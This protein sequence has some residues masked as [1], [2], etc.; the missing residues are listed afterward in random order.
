MN[1][2]VITPTV[3]PEG[4]ELVAKA[5][6]RQTW[7][8]FEWLICSPAEPEPV[9][10][11]GMAGRWIPDDFEGGF[12][13]LNRAYNKLFKEAQGELIVSLQ[14]WV[15]V[16]PEGLEKFWYQ[17]NATGG[18]IT[19]VG[20]QYDRLGPDGKPIN[21][22]W[23][24]P[25]KTDKYGSFYLC[26]WED[27]EWNWAAIPREAIFEAGG[28]DEQLDFLGYGG[29]QLQLMERINALRYKTYIDQSNESFTLRH[30]RSKHGGEA[31]WNANHILFN[32]EYDKRK[33][34]LI[35]A[36]TWP[37]LDYLAN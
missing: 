18:V 7:D 20:D 10:I 5:L 25:R 2:S 33:K 24:D 9:F 8:D 35:E 32:G 3:R 36:G 13:S 31:K 37:R 1:I 23:E 29:D 6:S 11:E 19:G 34:E 16:L 28:M 30:D 27:I 21:K 26:N 12:W 22:V 17:Y 4:L 15:Y 14:D